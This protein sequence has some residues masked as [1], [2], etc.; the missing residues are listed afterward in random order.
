MEEMTEVVK[1]E[2]APSRAACLSTAEP[3]PFQGSMLLYSTSK[4]PVRP[5]LPARRGSGNTVFSG[6]GRPQQ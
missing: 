6:L 1:A 5:A 4:G 3:A 2:P